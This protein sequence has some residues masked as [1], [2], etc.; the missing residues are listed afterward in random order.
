[1]IKYE[2]MFQGF[3]KSIDLEVKRLKY[4]GDSKINVR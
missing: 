3:K 1:M 2:A 4:F